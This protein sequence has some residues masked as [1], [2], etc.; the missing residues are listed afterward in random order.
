MKQISPALRSGLF[1]LVCLPGPLAARGEEAVRLVATLPVDSQYQ[2]KT[3]VQLSGTLTMPAEQGKPAPKPVQVSGQS[4]IEYE[5]RVLALDAAG[6]VQKTARFF[7]R[8]ELE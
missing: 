6:Q 7:R 8:V 4:A 2:V 3:R 5:E 1:A